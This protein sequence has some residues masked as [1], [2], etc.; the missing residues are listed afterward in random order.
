MPTFLV[1]SS[2][3]GAA[4][5]LFQ[6]LVSP[7]LSPST[8]ALL[9]AAA[10]LAGIQRSTV[11]IC[12]ILVEGT[13][14]VKTVIPV[15]ITVIVA[16]YVGDLISH[17][18]LYETAILEVK[19]YPYL[20]RKEKKTYDVFTCA[21][22]MTKSVICLGPYE[23]VETLI[24]LLRETEHNGFPVVDPV[25]N[26][27]L[28]LVRRDQLVALLEFG[29]F[30]AEPSSNVDPSDHA[31][32]T[33]RGAQPKWRPVPGVAESPLMHLVSEGLGWL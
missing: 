7:D 16:R 14:Q 17:H 8:F 12:V 32:G 25:S 29:I 33:R 4:G 15:I 6:D 20:E 10:L 9:G 27:F 5:M 21:D 1:G 31:S 19:R 23:Q 3:G 24:K 22:I 30:E 28:G 2:L 26:E 18:G 11:S 13:G